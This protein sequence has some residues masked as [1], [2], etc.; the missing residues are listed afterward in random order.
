LTPALL[1]HLPPVRFRK[2]LL[3][4]MLAAIPTRVMAQAQTDYSPGHL[5]ELRSEQAAPRTAIAFD[6]KDFDK[7]VGF[8]QLAPSTIATVTRDGGHYL[9]RLTG[10]INVEFFPESQTKF[11]ATVV[12]AQISFDSDADGRVTAMVLHQAG[13]EQ[14][15][16]R[17]SA[18]TA[19]AIEDALAVRIKNNQPSPGTEAAV[20]RQIESMEMGAQDF[21]AMAPPL[22]AAAR[23][24][25]PV[26]SQIISGLGPFKSMN[27]RNVGPGGA[28]IYDVTFERGH[29][30]WRIS[31][32]NADGKIQGMFF[33]MLP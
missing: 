31:P 7:F 12:H 10:Q 27:F 4:A 25:W 2:L 29:V 18:E 14:T 15:A 6:P 22:A 11:F 1:A 33:R 23:E 3:A 28:D 17:V 21:A 32:L 9:S 19:K 20:R 8:Y 5:A 24:Q 13:L 16:P 26:S 30:E